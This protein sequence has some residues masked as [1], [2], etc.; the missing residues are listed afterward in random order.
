VIAGLLMMLLPVPVPIIDQGRQNAGLFSFLRW[1][2][3]VFRGNGPS[4]RIVSSQPTTIRWRLSIRELQ[5]EQRDEYV[6]HAA[7]S[8]DEVIG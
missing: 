7:S 3:S 8:A 2:F 4:Y 1:H 5:L 6:L